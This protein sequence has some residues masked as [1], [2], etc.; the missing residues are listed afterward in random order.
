MSLMQKLFTF[1]AFTLLSA[2]TFTNYCASAAMPKHYVSAT[3]A[4]LT[5]ETFEVAKGVEGRESHYGSFKEKDLREYPLLADLKDLG[6]LIKTETIS[7]RGREYKRPYVVETEAVKHK[8]ALSRLSTPEKYWKDGEHPKDTVIP[9]DHIL[10]M[11]WFQFAYRLAFELNTLFKTDD[12]CEIMEMDALELETNPHAFFR[13]ITHHFMKLR[14]VH[15]EFE[16]LLAALKTHL[17]ADS[18]A[19]SSAAQCEDDSATKATD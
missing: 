12:Q 8:E 17:D 7:L 11:N 13:G 3:L 14:E 4:M 10:T 15:G 9:M 6:P 1:M 19:A 5:N 2:A 18:G 16:R